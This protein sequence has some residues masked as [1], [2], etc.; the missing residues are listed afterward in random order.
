MI[1]KTNEK[2]LSIKE[3]TFNIGDRYNNYDG[4]IMETD[5][6]EIKMGIS[7]Y[8]SCCENWGYLMTNDNVYEFIGATLYNITE[9]NKLLQTKPLTELEYVEEGSCMFINFETSNGTLQFVAYNEHNGYYGHE[10][11]LISKQLLVDDTL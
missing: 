9:T 8:Q 2:I 6:Q 11:V 3:S 4:Y 7:N 10:A 1:A 5:Q